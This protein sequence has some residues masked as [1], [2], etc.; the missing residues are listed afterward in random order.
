MAAAQEIAA[1]VRAAFEAIDTDRSG[2]ID[3]AEL[4]ALLQ[5]LQPQRFFADHDV[6]A[7]IKEMGG[8]AD[9]QLP[10]FARWWEA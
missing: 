10:A 2:G 8:A 9:V 6:E 1:D 4:K 5:S 7:A 3:A